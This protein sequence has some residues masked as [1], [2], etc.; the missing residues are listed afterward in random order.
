MVGNR[1]TRGVL[2]EET[3]R[4]GSCPGGPTPG[5]RPALL[6]AWYTYSRS[7]NL[8]VALFTCY[9]HL[10]RHECT[11]C[12][13][14]LFLIIIRCLGHSYPPLARRRSVD[15]GDFGPTF[16]DRP[17]TLSR[18]IAPSLARSPSCIRPRPRSAVLL[19]LTRMRDRY[20]HTRH[21]YVATIASRSRKRSRRGPGLES[22]CAANERGAA[23]RV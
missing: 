15:R 16:V 10:Q 12:C 22:H 8:F 18:P 9:S 19:F 14:L 5:T 7:Y 11:N 21:V 13:R 2:G 6:I 1:Q 4:R 3:S 17:P 23:C 20:T